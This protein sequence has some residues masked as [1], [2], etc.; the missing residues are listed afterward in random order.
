MILSTVFSPEEL[1]EAVSRVDY[2]TSVAPF[3]DHLRENKIAGAALDIF[4]TEP[5]PKDSPL[6][7]MGNVMIAPH[8]GAKSDIYVQQMANVFQHHLRLFLGG[9][10]LKMTKLI[11]RK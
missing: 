4:Q 11:S 6:W 7:K 10:Y 2:F 9:E 5:L 3:T 8:I 1:V